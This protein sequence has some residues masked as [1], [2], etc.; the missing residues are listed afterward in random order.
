MSKLKV[1]F[2]SISS[3][4]HLSIASLINLL[5]LSQRQN[6]ELNNSL[7]RFNQWITSIE[8]R[9]NFGENWTK[10][11]FFSGSFNFERFNTFHY[12]KHF[13]YIKLACSFNSVPISLRCKCNQSCDFLPIALLDSDSLISMIRVTKFALNSQY[14][15]K[16]IKCTAKALIVSK[17]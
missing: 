7:V 15:L 13:C 9:W 17:L 11:I 1:H 4:K 12:Y 3:S 2:Q 10:R 8:D 5:F 14:L 16:F 6:N